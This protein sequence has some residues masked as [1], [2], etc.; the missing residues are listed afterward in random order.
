MRR[1][2][3]DTGNER[4]HVLEAARD[5]AGR[6]GTARPACGDSQIKISS[7]TSRAYGHGP[8]TVSYNIVNY[9]HI[10]D[11]VVST[12]SGVKDTS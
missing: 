1:P 10:T 12:I 7:Y 11:F 8:A 3:T 5:G 6:R 4:V 9:S 2:S